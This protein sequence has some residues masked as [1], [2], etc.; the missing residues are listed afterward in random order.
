MTWQSVLKSPAKDR[1]YKLTQEDITQMNKLKEEGKSNTEIGLAMGERGKEISNAT[2]IYW[3]D[4]E[5]RE[6]QR[7]KNAIRK[8]VKGIQ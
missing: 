1:R 4:K 5:Q 2:V 8:Y 6:K 3:T 7:A